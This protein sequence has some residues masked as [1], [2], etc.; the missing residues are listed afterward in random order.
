MAHFDLG[1]ALARA[2]AEPDSRRAAILREAE[3][4]FVERG[5]DGVTVRDI[6][7]A[8][9]VNIAT[10][11]LHWKT[12]ATLYEAVC[13]LH[14]S[15]LL[16]F[17]ERSQPD[18]TI[19]RPSPDEEL[20]YWAGRAIDLLVE[21]PAVAPLALQ[22]VSGQAP[23]DLP[24]L[25]RHDV[26]LFRGLESEIQKRMTH[27]QQ[28]SVEPILALLC[29]FYFTIVAFSDSPLQQTLLGGSVY[30][31]QDVKERVKRFS[32]V[33]ASRLVGR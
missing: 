21:R 25:L 30:D 29:F 12:K 28:A 3:R 13:R 9:G 27:D 5:F 6:A 7:D 4:L 32:R 24:A 1:A 2:A 15:Y 14:A 18:P 33:L 19:D 16:A 20:A 31:D 10:L 23:A 17:F 26:A 22:S 11:H 8:A